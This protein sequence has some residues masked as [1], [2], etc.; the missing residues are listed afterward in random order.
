[1]AIGAKFSGQDA[2]RLREKRIDARGLTT[3]QRAAIDAKVSDACFFSSKVSDAK[4]LEKMR[5]YIVDAAEGKRF[6][7][8]NDFIRTMK[9]AMGAGPDAS[10]DSHGSLTDITSSRRLGLIYDFQRERMDAEV[11]LAQGDDPDH[12]FVYPAFELVRKESRRVPRDWKARWEEAGGTLYDGRM[13]ALRDDPIWTKISRFGS[14]VPPFDFNSGMGLEEVDIEE[15]ASLGLEVPSE[16]DYDEPEDEESG[17]ERASEVERIIDDAPEDQKEF[18]RTAL[19]GADE[20]CNAAAVKA[21][22]EGD[23]GG[24]ERLPEKQRNRAWF[25]PR[26]G[27]KI[28]LGSDY[29]DN[30][31]TIRHEYFHFVDHAIG[32]G[33]TYYTATR[34]FEVMREKEAQLAAKG[35]R[36]RENEAKRFAL[37]AQKWTKAMF[38]AEAEKI[39][40]KFGV[41]VSEVEAFFRGCGVYA[42]G[43][44]AERFSRELRVDEVGRKNGAVWWFSKCLERRD[45]G[46]AAQCFFARE[47]FPK[48]VLEKS[49]LGPLSDY[50]G[51]LT[52]NKQLGAHGIIRYGHRD[53]YY[54]QRSH[55]GGNSGNSELFANFGAMLGASD[56]AAGKIAVAM[57][58]A[59]SPA[60]WE[61]LTNATKEF[62][63][64]RK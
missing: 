60:I 33:N 22:E 20:T 16:P 56:T 51:T 10:Q 34:E 1:M 50:V 25:D 46:A 58:R 59:A 48:E 31:G 8:R 52:R 28:F 53:S 42:D 35:V 6:H 17:E 36:A 57:A 5:S 54:R 27:N 11:F 12:R 7:N 47:K 29:L 30:A 24:F 43:E 23:F 38:D 2:S 21:A 41:G 40:A 37:N 3:A 26:K 18:Y 19:T 64:K 49:P 4:L 13:V 9:E 39:L 55:K 63:E 32:V 61:D 62:I 15:A 44:L 45:L 14:P